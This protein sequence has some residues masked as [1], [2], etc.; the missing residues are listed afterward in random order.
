MKD[1][2]R[3]IRLQPFPYEVKF[4]MSHNLKET[5][6]R[7]RKKHGDVCSKLTANG[8]TG[9]MTLHD[10]NLPTMYVLM[11]YWC[12]V[13]FIAHEV[14]HI[15]RAMLTYVGAG[16]DNEVVAYYIGWLSKEAITFNVNESEAFDK[17]LDKEKVDVVS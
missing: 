4:V 2:I 3:T 12:D 9:A 13:G 7:L 16:L 15:V 6:R 1:K 17:A 8:R 14:W 11:P 5:E 10:R